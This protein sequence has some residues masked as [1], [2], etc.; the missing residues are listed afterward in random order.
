LAKAFSLGRL[1]LSTFEKLQG[2]TIRDSKAKK[3]TAKQHKGN[4]RKEGNRGTNQ[5]N[6]AQNLEKVQNSG[7]DTQANRKRKGNVEPTKRTQTNRRQKDEKQSNN[8]GPC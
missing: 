8:D 3:G 5:Q 1:G 2:E 4:D 7:N 6:Q